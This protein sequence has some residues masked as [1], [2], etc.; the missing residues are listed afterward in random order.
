MIGHPDLPA[1]MLE[2]NWADLDPE[3][4]VALPLDLRGLQKPDQLT[5][6]NAWLLRQPV[7]TLTI[8]DPGTRVDGADLLVHDL[9]GAEELLAAIGRNP[10]AAAVLVQTTRILGSLHCHQALAV[11]SLA[12]ATLQ[13]GR[14]FSAWLKLNRRP[15]V[16]PPQQPVVL[17][18]R[19][20]DRLDIRLNSPA[21]RNAFSVAMRDK[22]SEAFRLVAMDASIR[23]VHVSAE[24]PCFSAGGDLTEFGSSSDPAAAHQV[25]QLRM[26]AQ[27]LAQ[28][29]ARYHFHLHGACVGAGIELPAFAGHISAA[30]GSWF[31]LPEVAMGLI[32]GAGGCVSLTAR[33][34]RQ[35][36]NYLA[37]TGRRLDA[38]EALAWGL[39]DEI[40]G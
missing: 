30:R 23:Q 15:A 29:Q 2:P 37:I 16:A 3:H 14:E 27:Y 12:Y 8:A 24:G 21:N 32:P 6:I 11:E 31:Q 35:R 28:E 26:P 36:T 34:G 4:R 40:R 38:E 22:L 25:R 18:S 5:D 33:I 20:Q 13:G 7:P 10:R 1:L 9:A 19:D 17:T 39:I